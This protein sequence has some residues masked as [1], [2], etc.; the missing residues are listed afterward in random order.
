MLDPNEPITDFIL[1]DG[2]IIINVRLK[3]RFLALRRI[4]LEGNIHQRLTAR[5]CPDYSMWEE[6]MKSGTKIHLG[7]ENSNL[8]GAIR[9]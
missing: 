9:N 5:F 2:I 3:L 6:N 4:R 1:F 7:V 8:L